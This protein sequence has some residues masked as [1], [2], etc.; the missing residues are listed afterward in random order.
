MC[1]SDMGC[2]LQKSLKKS[3][4][5]F[6]K[7]EQTARY[8]HQP[9]RTTQKH[10]PSGRQCFQ[11][12]TPGLTFQSN[13]LSTTSPILATS[14]CCAHYLYTS[15]FF[16]ILFSLFGTAN[17]TIYS[18]TA[19]ICNRMHGLWRLL[20]QPS[21]L[22]ALASMATAQQSPAKRPQNKTGAK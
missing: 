2:R 19:N 17:S 7:S 21:P 11:R 8:R 15:I 13:F 22:Q 16:H 9:Y 10:A 5:L 20:L 3:P 6:K 1:F 4:Q 18:S 12:A 14:L